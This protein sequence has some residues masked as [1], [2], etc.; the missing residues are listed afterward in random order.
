[1]REERKDKWSRTGTLS[2]QKN[3]T[4]SVHN[5]SFLGGQFVSG[6]DHSSSEDEEGNK[7][8]W[9]RQG[10]LSKKNKPAFVAVPDSF[11]D[12]FLDSQK[13]PVPTM[14]AAPAVPSLEGAAGSSK[15]KPAFM[16]VSES[17]L[18]NN[19]SLMMSD[20]DDGT[21][22]TSSVDGGAADCSV[23][24]SAARKAAIAGGRPPVLSGIGT[25]NRDDSSNRA[26]SPRGPARIAITQ[27]FIHS[28][29][30]DQRSD[31]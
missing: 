27:S 17:F 6:S 29:S 18:Q 11:A 9:V 19:S 28:D 10:S 21:N 22:A 23:Q 26:S 25:L 3:N 12:S 30:E 13:A 7:Q 14:R 31:V 20:S 4:T 2:K 15:K 8:K 16:T 1:M 24:W 5:E